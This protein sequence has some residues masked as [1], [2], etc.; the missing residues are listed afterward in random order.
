MRSSI[1]LILGVLALISATTY[2]LTANL[3]D[4]QLTNNDCIEIK[5]SS[6]NIDAIV[7]NH[8]QTPQ[9]VKVI[10]YISPGHNMSEGTR[11]LKQGNEAI[12]TMDYQI[13]ELVHEQC[14]PSN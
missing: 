6:D 9:I 3:E 4:K 5:M 11:C 13:V 7:I 10:Y 14:N 2:L 1:I 12:L 8:C